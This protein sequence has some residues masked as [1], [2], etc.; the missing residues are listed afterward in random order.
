MK[1][2][3][4][5]W[6]NRRSIINASDIS[7]LRPDDD[8]MLREWRQMAKTDPQIVFING[9]S[10]S[11]FYRTSQEKALLANQSKKATPGE[12]PFLKTIWKDQMLRGLSE[13]AQGV[14]IQYLDQYMRAEG[15]IGALYNT[16]VLMQTNVS[17][18]DVQQNINIAFK[19]GK[20]VIE[21][22]MSVPKIRIKDKNDP[23]I[24][25]AHYEGTPLMAA[26]ATY[27]ISFDVNGHATLSVKSVILEHHDDVTRNLYDQR[28]ILDKIKVLFQAIHEEVKTLFKR[29][30]PDAKKTKPSAAA[31]AEGAALKL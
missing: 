3:Y 18:Q 7:T 14:A 16:L 8:Q 4:E 29:T 27:E 11:S 10:L 24:E 21:H 26:K 13:Q 6:Q 1:K 28:T 12:A 23:M 25:V 9:K 15:C 5:L 19:D 17:F 20:I 22:E 31:N 30:L 2:F